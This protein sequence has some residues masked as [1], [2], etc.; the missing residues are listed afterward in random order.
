MPQSTQNWSNPL[1]QGFQNVG[2]VLANPL[3]G[4]TSIN[5]MSMK[6]SNPLGD[7][8]G[9]FGVTTSVQKPP[10]QKL[11][12]QLELPSS[13]KND[14]LQKLCSSPDL[15]TPLDKFE[16]SKI[17]QKN[18]VVKIIETLNVDKVDIGALRKLV[19][20]GIP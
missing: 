16:S 6:S 8:L 19:F 10:E 11:E 14:I 7:P 2:S 1:S 9:G 17:K 13:F 5:N 20:T 18:K 12:T 3:G 4:S 15:S